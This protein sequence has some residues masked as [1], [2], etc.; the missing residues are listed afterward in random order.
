MTTRKDTSVIQNSWHDAQRVSQSDMQ[1]EQEHKNQTDA[2]IIQNHFGS[3]VLLSNA[4]QAVLFDSD[5]LT[6]AQAAIEASGDFD[7]TG[8][9]AHLQPSD[10]N[11]GTQLEVELTGSNV[12]GR[13][14]TRVAVIGLSF[15]GTLQFDRFYFYKDEK[16]VTSKHYASILT[17][18][19][20]DFKGNNQ[21]SRNNGGRIVVRE[22]ESFRV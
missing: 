5:D 15:E 8:M 20:S 14:S 9:D 17:I 21:C 11:L 16:Q 7:G 12:F 3:G 2:G 10:S 13:L 22:A 6:A 1:V 19:F 4:S 18:L